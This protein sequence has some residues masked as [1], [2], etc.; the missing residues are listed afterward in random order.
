MTYAT[1]LVNLEAGRSNAHLLQAAGDVAEWFQAGVIGVTICQP[2]QTVYGDGYTFGD[3]LE[4]DRN[5][6]EK[7]TRQTEAEFRAKL[8][9]RVRALD[10][11]SAASVT[12]LADQ[13]ARE[14]RRA[15]LVLTSATSDLPF[16]VSRQV[17][18]GDF[19][20]QVGRPVLIVAPEPARLRL[21]R[22]VIGWKDTRES[23][24]ATSDAL[25]LLKKAT[26]VSIVEIV[27]EEDLG[28]ARSRLGDVAGWLARHGIVA[29]I[30]TSASVHDDAS[31]L[32]AI[33]EERRADI[34]VA[35]AYGHSRLREWALGGVT[36]NLLRHAQ[37][38]SFVSH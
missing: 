26:D 4:V 27:A 8:E 38:S 1:L 33:A 15:D 34:I 31:H 11:C 35:G 9:T 21:E 13:L 19:V 2:L 6:I 29:E 25:P 32:N 28:A 7:E 23:R 37:R 30:L 20:M 18:N 36:R 3:L 5:E 12:S 14:A 17:S 10:W 24:R 22:V 16:N